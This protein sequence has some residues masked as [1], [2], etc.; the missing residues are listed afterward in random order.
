MQEIAKDIPLMPS[1]VESEQY[2][3]AIDQGTT[4]AELNH[5]QLEY[6]FE[7][8]A[9]LLISKGLEMPAIASSTRRSRG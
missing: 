1:I 5:P 3:K 8:V 6:P 2:K 4:L 7:Q 9:Q